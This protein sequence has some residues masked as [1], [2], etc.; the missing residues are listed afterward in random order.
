MQVV[1]ANPY[2]GIITAEEIIQKADMQFHRELENFVHVKPV[3]KVTDREPKKDKQV[4][5]VRLLNTFAASSLKKPVVH[6]QAFSNEAYLFCVYSFCFVEK[7]K[8]KNI[9][10][11]YIKT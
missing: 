8:I 10:M 6:C 1:E 3:M 4:C 5:S 9:D 11:Y 2:T 7:K